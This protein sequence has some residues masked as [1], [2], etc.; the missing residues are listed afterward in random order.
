MAE[1]SAITDLSAPVPVGGA[2]AALD[3]MVAALRA[4]VPLV[5][6]NANEARQRWAALAADPDYRRRFSEGDVQARLEKE[7]LDNLIASG[8]DAEALTG[9]PAEVPI[10]VTTGQDARRADVLSWAADMRNLWQ[11]IS[12]EHCEAAI[13]DLLD[14]NTPVPADLLRTMQTWMQQAMNDPAFVDMLMRKDRGAMARFTYANA[15]IGK[16]TVEVL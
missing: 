14:P 15:V 1:A 12:P 16:G 2:A 11:D 5:P 13:R 6:T 7:S 10:E 4:P 8:T 3:Q 9:G